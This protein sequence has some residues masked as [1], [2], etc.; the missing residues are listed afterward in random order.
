MAFE[1]FTATSFPYCHLFIHNDL[2]NKNI[3]IL[4]VIVV[5]EERRKEYDD[6]DDGVKASYMCFNYPFLCNNVAL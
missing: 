3:F 5:R 6:E 2:Q 1:R 4:V